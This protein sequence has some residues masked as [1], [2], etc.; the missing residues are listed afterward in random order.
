M[1]YLPSQATTRNSSSSEISCTVTSGK[2]VTICCSGASSALFLNSKS[3][4]A[5]DNARFPLTRPKST[6]P[7]AAVIR[8]FSPIYVSASRSLSSFCINYLRFVACDRMRAAWLDLLRLEHSENLQHFPAIV[9]TNPQH[10]KTTTY[11]VYLL[12][13]ED[14]NRCCATRNF[15]L[16]PWVYK[17]RVSFLI[18]VC[19]LYADRSKLLGPSP[20]NRPSKHA[21]C[22]PF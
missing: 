18:S 9:S 15:F 3:P 14:S 1:F 8:A 10:A 21:Q 20:R 11:N 17:A 5:L 7:P 16:V 2:A 13:R 4:I 6:K 19:N 12:R 22:H